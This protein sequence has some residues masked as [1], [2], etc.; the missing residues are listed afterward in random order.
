MVSAHSNYSLWQGRPFFRNFYLDSH[1]EQGC[2][3]AYFRT[4]NRNLGKFWRDL[5]EVGVFYGHLVYCKAIWCILRPF[6][7]FY[8][9]W[10]YFMIIW[11]I[12]SVF[13][14]LCQENSGN[15]D[16]EAAANYA[17]STRVT[18]L[19]TNESRSHAVWPDEFAKK[20]A[21]NVA[22]TRLLANLVH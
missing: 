20:I 18:R 19:D 14:T 4:K 21:Q 3:M 2:Q 17:S 8:V 7:I 6:G 13:G 12:F 1:T 10:V 16:T 9:Q 11:Y 15:P 22:Q 5:W